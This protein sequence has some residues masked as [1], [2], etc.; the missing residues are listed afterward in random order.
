[1]SLVCARLPG[2]FSTAARVIQPD[3]RAMW[4]RCLIATFSSQVF[5]LRGTAHVADPQGRPRGGP[6][7]SDP[8]H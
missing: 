2:G 8:R 7:V 5:G 4:Q 3:V 1:M 6:T